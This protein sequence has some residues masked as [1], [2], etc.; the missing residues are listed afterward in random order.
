MAEVTWKWGR[1]VVDDG[2]TWHF[3]GANGLDKTGVV[4]AVVQNIDLDGKPLGTGNLSLKDGKGFVP[5]GAEA[6]EV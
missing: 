6:K 5:F 1:K 2:K 4:G 3:T